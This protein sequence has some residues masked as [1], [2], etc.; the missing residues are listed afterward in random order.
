MQLK[1]MQ[2]KIALL[3]S[4]LLLTSAVSTHSNSIVSQVMDANQ[5][6]LAQQISL[7]ADDD[8]DEDDG[9]NDLD[10]LTMP[11]AQV[12]ARELVRQTREEQKN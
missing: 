11:V 12:A 2:A 9:L 6:A 7:F 3:G 5:Q 8:L 10:D 4:S 1:G